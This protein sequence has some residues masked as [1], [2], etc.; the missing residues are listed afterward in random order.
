[1]SATTSFSRRLSPLPAELT[2]L[3]GRTRETDQVRELLDAPAN[4]LV[5]LIGP[6]GVGKTRLALHVASTLFDDFA[7][8]V[9]YV[10]LASI[11]DPNQALAAIA[12]S[13]GLF[14]DAQDSPEDQLADLLHD[15]QLLLVLDNFEQ[16]L[17]AAPSLTNVLIRCPGV[18][19]L[20]TSQAPLGILGEQ[21]Y[22]LLPLSVPSSEQTTADD[23]LRSDAVA[24]K[25]R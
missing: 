4:R 17:G 23:I 22:P 15:R 7:E 16:I 13:F 8:D 3:L 12:Q 5:T 19:A 18:T 14:S 24:R 21:L 6:G 11:H 1:M 20:V 9:A 25:N 2:P 10:A